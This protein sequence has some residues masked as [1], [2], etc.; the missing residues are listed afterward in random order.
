VEKMAL[1]DIH[2]AQ[3]NFS[4]TEKDLLQ[5]YWL[6]DRIANIRNKH[7]EKIGKELTK[8]TIF[9]WQISF[10]KKVKEIGKQ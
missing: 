10:L 1:T 3:E 2:M 5:F 4:N 7:V 9:L 8:A 6:W